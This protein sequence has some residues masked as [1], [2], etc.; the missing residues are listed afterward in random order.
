MDPARFWVWLTACGGE[1]APT[2]SLDHH[3][4]MTWGGLTRVLP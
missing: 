3:A 1:V 2:R 4:V